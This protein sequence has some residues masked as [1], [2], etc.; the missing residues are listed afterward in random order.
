VLS[1]NQKGAIAETAIAHA[2]VKAGISVLQ[3]LAD[4]RYDLVFDLKTRFVRVQ[5]KWAVRLGDV[6]SVRC[7]SCRRARTGIVHRGYSPEEID[8]IAAYCAE[9]GRSFY[10]PM[11][12]LAGRSLVHLRL[13]SARNNQRLGVNWADDFDFERLHWHELKGP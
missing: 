11:E 10:L 4:E 1:T 9:L 3:P 7:R 12:I 2:A 8:A 13:T 5:C 6:V